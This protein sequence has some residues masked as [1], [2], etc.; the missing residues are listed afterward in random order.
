MKNPSFQTSIFADQYILLNWLAT[1]GMAEIYLAAKKDRYSVEQLQVIK[2]MLPRFSL[3]RKFVDMLVAEAKIG[4]L[5]EHPNIVKVSD[6]GSSSDSFYLAM[7]FVFGKSLAQLL[8]KLREKRQA[9]APSM[10][11]T[12]LEAVGNALD[13]THH[14]TDSS[15]REL[16]LVHRDV[17]PGNILIGYNGEVRLSDFGIATVT[18][19]KISTEPHAYGKLPYMAPEQVRNQLLDYRADLYSLTAIFFEMLSGRKPFIAEESMDLQELVLRGEVPSIIKLAPHLLKGRPNDQTLFDHFL[20]SCLAK[21]IGHRPTSASALAEELRRFWTPAPSHKLA[22]LMSQLFANEKNQEE[23]QIQQALA[24]A[25]KVLQAFEKNKAKSTPVAADPATAERTVFITRDDDSA[26]AAT[27][28]KPNV[29]PATKKPDRATTQDELMN[30]LLDETGPDY[31]FDPDSGKTVFMSEELGNSQAATVFEPQSPSYAEETDNEP[32]KPVAKTIG[33]IQLSNKVPDHQAFLQELE[34]NPLP[35]I[36]SSIAAPVAAPVVTPP[37]LEDAPLELDIPTPMLSPAEKRAT[38]KTAEKIPREQQELLRNSLDKRKPL[39]S[40]PDIHSKPP[41]R[42]AGMFIFIITAVVLGWFFYPQL[43]QLLKPTNSNS[44]VV[45]LNPKVMLYLFAEKPSNSKEERLLS[46]FLA[47]AQISGDSTLLRLSDYFKQEYARVTQKNDFTMQ[48]EIVG[49]HFVSSK[50]PTE[51][52]LF[53]RQPT[54]QY[55]DRQISA[56]GTPIVTETAAEIFK[57]YL[58]VYHHDSDHSSRYPLEFFSKRRKREGIVFVPLDREKMEF[59]VVNVAH[60]L[61]HLLGAKDKF[62]DYGAPIYPQ[63]FV[64]PTLQPLYP[65]TF[66]EIMARSIPIESDKTQPVTQLKQV[67]IGSETA[68]EIGWLNRTNP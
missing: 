33:R 59:A 66:A 52:K 47:P 29:K 64:E 48:L 53:E 62:N 24:N 51:E 50:P 56:L 42:K 11:L 23:L 8:A 9:I 44:K 12:I 13:Y 43:N 34:A 49:P 18:R 61:L 14:A 54:Y 55:F 17:T 45:A 30:E 65:Q 68:Y 4:A 41:R 31:G 27:T 46:R 40:E 1:G 2:K 5:L 39:T 20:Q 58:F 38:K 63:G 7:D 19:D 35:S 37:A 32:P 21:E 25:S 3:D 10:A 67:R 22:E 15:G 36:V 57:L 16:K 28:I 6:L 60:E 26:P